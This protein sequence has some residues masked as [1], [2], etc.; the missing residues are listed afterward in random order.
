[1]AKA[2]EAFF[3][4]LERKALEEVLP[5]LLE[6]TLARGWRAVIR[7]GSL[8]R[9]EALDGHLWSY[10]DDSFLP[11]GLAR[12]P[13]AAAQPILID[14]DQR[15]TNAAQIL[16]LVDGAEPRDWQALAALGFERT[17]LIFDGRDA[18]AV[19]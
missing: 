12:E 18:N 10:R 9:A 17:A 8:E 3:Y 16:F 6:R 2:V 13:H 5:E 7:P 11:H 1:M 4:H 15:N 14:L 19:A